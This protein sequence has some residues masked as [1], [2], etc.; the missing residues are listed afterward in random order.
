MSEKVCEPVKRTR[1]LS[2]DV[3]RLPILVSGAKP[4]ERKTQM[5]TIAKGS[6]PICGG[7]IA[8]PWTIPAEVVERTKLDSLPP[9]SK[10]EVLNFVLALERAGSE[11]IVN[12]AQNET[13]R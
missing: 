2:D 8:E 11:T 1:C 13:R 10:D 3:L 7:V 5:V 12:I 9:L 4:S 6:C